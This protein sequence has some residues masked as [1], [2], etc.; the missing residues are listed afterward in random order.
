[1]PE[2]K[3]GRKRRG[4]LVFEIRVWYLKIRESVRCERL[5]SREILKLIRTRH[6]VRIGMVCKDPIFVAKK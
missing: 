6:Y 1:L 3:I 2:V 4:R 5:G